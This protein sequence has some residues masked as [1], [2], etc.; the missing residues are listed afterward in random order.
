MDMIRIGIDPSSL[1]AGWAVVKTRPL[2]TKLLGY[3]V[4][5]AHNSEVVVRCESIL[6]QCLEGIEP[7]IPSKSDHLHT[8]LV[9]ERPHSWGGDGDKMDS[10]ITLALAMGYL[11]RGL[12]DAIKPDLIK[13]PTPQQWKGNL[14][15]ELVAKRLNE[16][17]PELSSIQITTKNLNAIEAIGIALWS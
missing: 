11:L 8:T 16:T 4:A 15:K 3:G 1:Y 10:L 5:D 17:F 2:P 13:I 6:Q 7:L 12:S 9:L 14:K